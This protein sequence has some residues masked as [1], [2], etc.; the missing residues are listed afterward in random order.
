MNIAHS[1]HRWLL[2]NIRFAEIC[3]G[4]THVVAGLYVRFAEMED[5]YIFWLTVTEGTYSIWYSCASGSKDCPFLRLVDGST[6]R[7]GF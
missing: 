6:D 7:V 4:D 5:V 1:Q 3:G 2:K